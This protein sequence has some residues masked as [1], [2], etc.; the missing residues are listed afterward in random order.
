MKTLDTIPAILIAIAIALSGYWIGNTLKTGK[1]FDRSVQVKGLSERTVEADLG[2]WPSSITIA[3]NDLNTI[4]SKIEKQNEIVYKFFID[5]GFKRNEL[6]QGSVNI[7]DRKAN[8]YGTNIY[9]EFRYVAK[10]DF[11]VRTSN[12]ALLQSALSSSLGLLS[13][14]IILGSK[15]TWR[16]IEYSFSALSEL[17]PAMIEEATKNA[18][19]VAI[20]FAEDSDSKVGKIR[21][22]RQGLFSISDLDVNTPHI[23]KVRVVSTIDYQL[24]D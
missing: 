3:G 5:Q 16:P 17:K 20:K 2:V 21:N 23:K 14:G 22:A 19:E 8:L 6:Q 18:R 1:A 12:I 15:N 11:T 4:Q 9:Q 7:E 10:S 24:E 13:D